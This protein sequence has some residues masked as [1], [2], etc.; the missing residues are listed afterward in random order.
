MIRSLVITFVSFSATAV[1]ILA[2]SNVGPG[3]IA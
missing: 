1:L 3:I 2:S